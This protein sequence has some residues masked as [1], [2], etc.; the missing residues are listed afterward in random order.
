MKMAGIKPR[1]K[2]RKLKTTLSK[3][4]VVVVTAAGYSVC[5]Y[6]QQARNGLTQS[7]QAPPDIPIRARQSASE[8]TA[9]NYDRV[10]ATVPQIREVLLADPGV[11]VELK[12]WVAQETSDNGQL[13]SDADLTDQA[14]FDRLTID[15]RFRS[16]ATRLVRQYGYLKPRLNPMSDEAKQQDLV[17]KE[18]A[19][20]IVEIEAQQD[21]AALEDWKETRKMER[22]VAQ[23]ASPCPVV[24]LVEDT[25]NQPNKYSEEDCQDLGTLQPRHNVGSPNLAPGLNSPENLP[26]PALPEQ[27]PPLL[28]GSPILRARSTPAEQVGGMTDGPGAPA[29][30]GS[31][32]AMSNP[33][34]SALLGASSDTPFRSGL[35]AEGVGIT[36]L[37]TPNGVGLQGLLGLSSVGTDPSATPGMQANRQPGLVRNH[38][39][40]YRREPYVAPDTIVHRSSPYSDIPSLYDLYVQAPS[41]NGVP[42]RFGSQVFHDGLRNPLAIPMDM[43]VGPDYV[44]GPGD[45]LSID[46]WGGITTRLVRAVD[47]EGRVALPEAGPVQVSGHSLAEVQQVV[48]K[49]V[50]SQFRG[51]SADV[52]VSRL[53]TVRVYVVGEVGEPGAYDIS[54]LSTP[55]NAVVAANGV[56]PRGS[57]RFLEHYRGR[58]LLE[59]VDAYDLL[60]RG[61]TPEAKKLENGD[62]LM[63]PAIGPQV[64]VTGMVRRPA[65]YELR[66]E[67]TLADVLGLAGGIL[68]AATLKHIEMQRLEAHEKRSMLSLDL[69]AENGDA[70]QL[71]SFKVQDGDEIHILPIAPYNQE[72]IYLQGHILRPGRYSYHDGMKLTDLIASYKDLLPEPAPHYGEIVRLNPPDFHPTV[73]SFD[74]AA[75]LANPAN[76]P[77]LKPLDTVR[78]FSRFDFEPAPAVWVGGEVRAPGKYNTSGQ[79][80]LRDAV[81]LAGGVLPDAELADAQLFRIEADGT[82]KILSVNLGQALA[83]NPIDNLALVPRDRLLIHRNAERVEPPTVNI[84]GEVAKPGRYPYTSNMRI[85]DLIHTAGG[86]KRS[87]DTTV[88][89][90]TRYSMNGKPG[91]HLEVSLPSVM[92]GNSTEDVALRMGDVL[93]IR[94]AP[95]WEDIG[96]TVTVRGEVLHPGS[97]GIQPGER[98][99]SVLERAGGYNH[100]AYPYGAVLMRREVREAQEAAHA[101]LVHRVQALEANVHLLPEGSEN[102]K[103]AKITALAQSESTLS[104]LRLSEPIGRVVI[105]IQQ[106]MERWKDTADDIAL[107]DGDVLVIPKK[108]NYVMVNGQVFNPTAVSYR[109]GRSGTWYLGQAGG[110]TPLA[111]KKGVFVIRADGSVIAAK[112]SQ[113]GWFSGN[114]L[115]SALRAGDAVIVP[116]RAPN[117]GRKDYTQLFQAAQVASSL[118]LA[119]AYIHP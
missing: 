89:D 68:P 70:P 48:Q 21:A 29:N 52:S 110:L 96:A 109:P 15:S 7:T 27:I 41:R 12:R 51:T 13:I 56:T 111:D 88:A 97:F 79:A 28:G 83:G 63:V 38:E 60:L 49:A 3:I 72:A 85:E 26:L 119:V 101:E 116:E 75:A 92:N 106:P 32:L 108:A 81:Y 55:L 34:T 33:Q 58:Q 82:S 107:R 67:K 19:K 30:T 73:E 45:S 74:L 69:S 43:P 2:R 115:D 8:L 24:G 37:A 59:Q 94:Q 16:V 18:R 50:G 65:I 98:L 66:D 91:E 10:A 61:V 76:A 57:L 17:L 6:G 39:P 54:S 78:I 44:V 105:H 25:N 100:Q 42:E 47:R 9:Q 77:N 64:T 22:V 93:A 118:A 102:E 114:P 99:S 5:A 4:I 1:R 46:L 95:G 20:K 84:T 23:Q 117:M 113:Q 87:A 14:I 11:M 104:Q 62:T 35:S 53:R 80:H 36:S 71:S 86:L 103:N 40:R 90:L 31:L 112:N